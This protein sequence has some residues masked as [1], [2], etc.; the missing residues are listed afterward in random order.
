M[1]DVKKVTAAK[2]KLGGAIYTAPLGTTLPT[3]ATSGLDMAF[4]PLGYVSEDGL[5]NELAMESEKIKAW[6]GDIV[7]VAQTEKTDAFTYVLIESLNVDVLKEVFGPDNVEGDLSTGISVKANSKE[8]PNR[9]LVVETVLKGGIVKRMVI[10]NA[11][12][13]SLGEIVYKDDEVVGYG[14]TVDGL[15]DENGNTHYEYIKAKGE[16]E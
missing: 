1:S 8:L 7:M 14:L 12:T 10:P 15:P 13:S 16:T 5:T 6:G 9:V 4:K 11:A 3:D 2:P